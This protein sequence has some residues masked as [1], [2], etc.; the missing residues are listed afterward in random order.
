MNLSTPVKLSDDCT[1]SQILEY[2]LME[3]SEPESQSHSYDLAL[4]NCTLIK[5]LVFKSVSEVIC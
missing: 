4:K 3:G 5:C 2:N 1:L